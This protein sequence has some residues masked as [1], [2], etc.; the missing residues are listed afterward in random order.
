MLTN[1]LLII[2]DTNILPILRE[3]IDQQKINVFKK[4]AAKADKVNLAENFKSK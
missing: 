2:I 3:Q 1:G 4:F